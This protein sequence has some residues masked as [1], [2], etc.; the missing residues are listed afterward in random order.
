M[1]SLLK[2]TAR[3]LSLSRLR[4]HSVDM[5]VRLAE[6]N[7]D[8]IVRAHWM[9]LILA[10][11]KDVRVTFKTHFMSEDARVF[12]RNSFEASPVRIEQML[13]F[14]K[15]FCNLTIGGLKFFF[16]SNQVQVG[17]GLP[18]VTRGFDELFF[19]PVVG[20]ST[21]CDKWRLETD[22]AK[23]DC[24][25]SFEF[26]NPLKLTNSGSENDMDGEGIEFF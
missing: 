18:L 8:A 14:F 3:E 15:E 12:S 22:K 4:S 1:V 7:S 5:S 24:A 20:G 6:Q 13:D 10:A 26:F 25:V 9:A 21:F 23:V 17:V 11:G 16:E 2:M 19:P